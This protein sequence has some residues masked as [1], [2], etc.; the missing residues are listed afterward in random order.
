LTAK[1]DNH[2]SH[3]DPATNNARGILDDWQAEKTG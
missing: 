1:M 2:D 3:M